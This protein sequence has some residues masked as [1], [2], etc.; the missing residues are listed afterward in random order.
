MLALMTL[1]I[2][3]S[4]I[5]ITVGPYVMA[6]IAPQLTQ[7]WTGRRPTIILASISG[8]AVIAVID[9]G[10]DAGHPDLNDKLVPGYDFLDGDDNPHD[11]YGHGSHVSGVAAG[12]THTA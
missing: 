3:T 1:V 12:E 10:I 4:G 5:W 7:I 2:Q 6:Q 8:L 9:T 11:T